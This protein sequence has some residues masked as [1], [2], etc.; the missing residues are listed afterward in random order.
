MHFPELSVKVSHSQAT[1]VFAHLTA[2]SSTKKRMAQR[3]SLPVETRSSMRP[4]VPTTMSTLWNK[5]RCITN[6]RS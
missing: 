6:T 4:G 2:S 3:S 1:K 5:Q